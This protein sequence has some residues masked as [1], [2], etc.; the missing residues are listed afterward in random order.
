MSAQPSFI[1]GGDTG[2]KTPEDLARLR[3][4][5]EALRG[6][7]A[8][9]TLGQGLSAIGEALG[10]RM[11]DS[12]ATKAE[13]N[14]R[15][16]G[17]SIFSAL[18]GGGGSGDATSAAL[19]P[20]ETSAASPGLGGSA[21]PAPD[22]SGNDIY[23]G[24]MDTVKG[25]ITNPNA[26][27]AVAA[28]GKAESGFSPG[29]VF[30]SWS[31]PSQSGQAGAAGGIMSWRAERLANMK[32]F[33]AANGGDPDRPSPQLQ[34]QFFLQEDPTLID[35]LNAAKSPAEAQ[36]MM[37]N[38]WKFAGYDRPGGEAGRRIAL[39]N[40]FASQFS[41]APADPVQVASLDPAAGIPVAPGGAVTSALAAPAATGP[42]QTPAQALSGVPVPTP[43]PR[44]QSPRSADGGGGPM[45]GAPAG[46][47]A[48]GDIKTGPDGKTYQYAETKGMAGAT[49]DFG[50]IPVN[51]GASAANG[52]SVQVAGG[53]PT[54]QQLM[55]AATDPRL[56]PEQRGVVGM[57]LKQKMAAA[58]PATQ[59]S[60][61][62]DR[63]DM[64][65]TRIETER[66][67]NPQMTPA[68]QAR[69]DFDERKLQADQE[70]LIEVG[71][72]LV[73]PKTH[74]AVYTGQQ[75]DWEKLEDG[76]LYNKRTGETKAVAAAPGGGEG[77]MFKGNAVDAQALNWLVNNNKVTREQ[78]AQI[79]A[80]KTITGPNGE[81]M[82]LTPQGIVAQMPGQA[83]Q[84]I[85]PPQAPPSGAQQ[86]A[87]QPGAPPV[88]VPAP[89]PVPSAPAPAAP[90]PVSP[91]AANPPPGSNA[92]IVP[93]T[94]PKVK[95]ANEQQQRDAKLYSVVEPEL[96][97]VEDN[98][99]ALTNVKD[100]ALSAVPYGSDYGADY[101]KSK[102][103]Q[104]ASNSLKTIIASYLYSV[105]GA[106]AA[107][108]EVEN[109]AAILTPKPGE[110]KESVDDKLAR[111]RAMV[112]AIK[113]GT[114][115]GAA[116]NGSGNAGTTSNGLKWSLEP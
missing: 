77:N 105:S 25:K 16:G 64:E 20:A 15:K 99:A 72:S 34:A 73:D 24:F 14:W 44:V 115:Q 47:P 86:A 45:L 92:G 41:G 7:A 19:G 61:E 11:A 18:F 58:D 75:T 60:M 36:Q 17:D 38:A 55:R 56:S 21:G 78:A 8:P 97:I 100:Q 1:F 71:G 69:L 39:A 106:T 59:L 2:V 42:Q 52:G 68:E 12:R 27:A 94:G 83:P 98:F 6:P 103:Y 40:S 49:G 51:T 109:Q 54:V 3:A 13:A 57:L 29:N 87:P 114:G 67:K 10:Y 74:Q 96:K 50:W 70:K 81:M 112:E 104:R 82:F 9:K 102:D 37:N 46:A 113:N 53:G 65:K 28:T 107:P 76:T 89:V 101:L 4:I 30:R 66:L 79:A 90:A 91:R 85:V 95:P 111:V 62:K 110:A 5:A 108:A 48:P 35:R 80:G 33:A 31:D 88:A 116:P 93:L 84:P 26:L 22:L 23:S 63:L 32:K 43:A